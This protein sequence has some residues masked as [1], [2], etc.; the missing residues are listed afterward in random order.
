MLLPFLLAM[1]S[2]TAPAVFAQAG[3]G[4]SRQQAS[5]SAQKTFQ[6]IVMDLRSDEPMQYVLVK[7]LSTGVEVETQREGQ[8]RIP[9]KQNDLLRFYYPGYRTDTLVVVEFDIKRIYLTQSGQDYRLEEVQIEAMTNAQLDAELDRAKK[10]GQIVETSI[11]R[12]GLRI[13]PSRWLGEAGKQAR[14]RFE[15]LQAEKDR[16]LVDQR[17]SAAA[18]QALTP[19]TGADLELFMTIYRPDVGFVKKAPDVDFNLYIMDSFTA[20]NKLTASQKDSLHMPPNL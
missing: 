18:I 12:G 13:S 16:R 4:N 5:P 8:F 15:L 6:G 3:A 10:E 1:G 14:H 19:L 9:A 2:V 11:E 17:F 7:N 20:F